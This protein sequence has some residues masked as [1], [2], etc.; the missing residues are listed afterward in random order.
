M[1]KDRKDTKKTRNRTKNHNR[2]SIDKALKQ[3]NGHEGVKEKPTMNIKISSITYGG[4]G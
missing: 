4:G 2:T 1:T 3:N